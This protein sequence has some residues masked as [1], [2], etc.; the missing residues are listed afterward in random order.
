VTEG[1]GELVPVRAMSHS[2]IANVAGASLSHPDTEGL[3]CATLKAPI[4][5]SLQMLGLIG[6]ASNPDVLTDV[7]TEYGSVWEAGS[8]VQ[9]TQPP[10][11]P[12]VDD[13]PSGYPEVSGDSDTPD[14]ADIYLTSVSTSASGVDAT[15]G[16]DLSVAA[17]ISVT[18]GACVEI[19]NPSQIQRKSNGDIA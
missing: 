5:S 14:I 16:P 6:A 18:P 9:P 4:A 12:L 7:D 13:I 1:S 2:S 10:H 15:S 19:R 17:C 3:M 8:E 11:S